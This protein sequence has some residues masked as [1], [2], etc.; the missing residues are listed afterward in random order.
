MQ[1]LFAGQE[2]VAENASRPPQHD[3]ADMVLRVA[4]EDVGDGLGMVELELT[5]AIRSE[6]ADRVAE[7]RR[8]GFEELRR[9]DREEG[10]AAETFDDARAR[11]PML[12]HP[13]LVCCVSMLLDAVALASRP[14]MP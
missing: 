9:V 8:V 1:G 7:A 12:L 6:E 3:S 5:K 11:R 2:A 14:S 4:G 13:H 10:S